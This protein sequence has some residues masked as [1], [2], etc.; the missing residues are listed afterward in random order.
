MEGAM[1]VTP[2]RGFVGRPRAAFVLGG[3]GN[4]GAIQVGMLQAL[5]ERGIVPDVVLGCSVGAL[6][7]AALAGDPTPDGI[8]R[9]AR[10]WR[11]LRAEDVFPTGWFNGPWMLLR[12]SL[13]MTSNAKLRALITATVP[14]ATFEEARV[15]LQVVATSLTTGRPYWFDSGPILEPILA[16]A[17]LPAVLPPVEIDGETYIDGAVVDNVPISR[18]VELGAERVY[19]LHVG[20]FER[21][22]PAPQRPIDVLVQAF[23]I[24]RNERFMRESLSERRG[25]SELVVLPGIDP[26]G[27]NKR[28][29]SRSIELMERAR[30]TAGAFL[31]RHLGAA[32]G[33]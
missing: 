2:L 25:G 12:R 14:F 21:A 26:G 13:S 32:S 27:Y 16:S 19:V 7:G 30:R 31:D 6:N 5:S 4:L 17:A 22:R 20:N 1:P 28:D 29:F 10:I 11:R 23:S 3:G 24:A 33:L 8:D 18:A 9:L 15:P